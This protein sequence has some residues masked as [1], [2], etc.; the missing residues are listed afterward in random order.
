MNKTLTSLPKIKV[1]SAEIGNE[2]D[3]ICRTKLTVQS[4][5][6]NLK[7]RVPFF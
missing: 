7:M 3:R 1:F 4:I 6:A 2:K 5:V